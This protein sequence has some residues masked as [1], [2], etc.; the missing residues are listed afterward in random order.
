MYK[1]ITMKFYC[2]I[3]IAFFLATTTNVSAQKKLT[4]SVDIIQEMKGSLFIGVHNSEIDFPEKPYK[5][6]IHKVTA[7]TME[8][9]LDLP[10]G[11][12][13]VALFHD[14]N[15]NQKLDTSRLGIPTEKYG[16]SN[17]A[18]GFIG[19]PSFEKSKF[20]LGKDSIIKIKLR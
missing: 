20:H 7:K 19:S 15:E 9:S 3:L 18:R 13:A 17:N 12:Y 1:N 11:E 2:A 4:I 16:F 10:E 5:G 8:I 6:I 14:Y